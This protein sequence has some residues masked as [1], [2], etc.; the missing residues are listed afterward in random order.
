MASCL[1]KREFGKTASGINQSQKRGGKVKKLFSIGVLMLII[2]IGG[3]TAGCG[4][5]SHEIDFVI[6]Y[7]NMSSGRSQNLESVV[8]T[9]AEWSVIRGDT[10]QFTELDVKYNKQ[11]FVENSLIVFAFTKSNGIGSITI[12]SVGVKNQQLMVEADIVL[13]STEMMANGIVIIEVIKTDIAGT[14][15]LR[16]VNSN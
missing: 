2:L 3:V 11:F 4:T 1:D 7:E 6:G 10:A 13:N 12:T 16:I 14:N 8:N 9:F 15:S 5:K